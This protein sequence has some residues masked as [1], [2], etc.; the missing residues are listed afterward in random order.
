M[1]LHAGPRH[2]QVATILRNRIRSGDL[3]PDAQLPTELQLI[4]SHA[5]S[6]TVVR[7]AM[8]TLE[9]E[10]LIRR[11]P[12]KGTFVR[13][14]PRANAEWAIGSL[15][16][17]KAYGAR[18]QLKILSHREVPAPEAVAKAL[19]IGRGSLVVEIRGMR[20]GPMGPL[21]YQR[22]YLLLDVGRSV[23][24]VNLAKVP[25]IDAME[26]ELDIHILR[27]TQWFT[28]VAA[29]GEECR[30]LKVKL[31]T[32]L[33]QIQRLFQSRERGPVEFGTTHFRPDRYQ[34]VSDIT[35][36]G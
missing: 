24:R 11:I 1:N 32:P 18:T 22:N 12:G 26:R 21:A 23:K 3:P 27:A 2:R 7:Q 30:L 29:Q 34:H 6:R 19:H 31:G 5:V 13:A 9:F 17:L 14:A 20:S 4:E 35:R 36:S 15:E 8:Q 16:D 10:G 33:L 28:A 25:M